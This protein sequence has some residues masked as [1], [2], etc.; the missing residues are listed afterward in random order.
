[1]KIVVCIK[2]VPM[3]SELPWDPKTGALKRDRSDGMMNP[4]C[5]NAIE[6]SLGLKETLGGEIDVLSMGPPTAEEVLREAAALGADRGFLLCDPRMAGADTLATSFTLAR[7]VEKVCPDFDLVVCGAG[8]SDSETAQ[9]G[10]QLAVELGVP[11][12]S[13]VDWIEPEDGLLRL[14]RVSD[15][16]HEVLEMDLPGLITVTARANSPRYSRLAGVEDAFGEFDVAFLD[17][18]ALGADAGRVGAAGSAT[19]ILKVFSPRAD[20]QGVVMKGAAKKVARR[21]LDEYSDRLG[22]YI[23]R[24][25][26]EP[27]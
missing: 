26:T 22:G 21:L 9:V 12:V 1:M 7:A 19:K 3:V 18:E 16:F 14:G 5:R 23:G 10:P 27:E 8:T 15:S 13:R 11:S 20:K 2:Q 24:D 6:A 25:L 17:A 4:L